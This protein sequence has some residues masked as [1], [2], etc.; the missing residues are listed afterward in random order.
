MRRALTSPMLTENPT[1]SWPP[2][3]VV[4]FMVS[5]QLFSVTWRIIWW[6]GNSWLHSSDPLIPLHFP[7]LNVQLMFMWWDI[8]L[9]SPFCWQPS[10][11]QRTSK[12]TSLKDWTVVLKEMSPSLKL[13]LQIKLVRI[14]SPIKTHRH[15][16]HG[17]TR[18]FW[19]IQWPKL[20]TVQIQWP[21]LHC[22]ICTLAETIS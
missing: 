9:W 4:N 3:W 13:D 6:M 7:V 21:N 5:T 12:G 11:G 8:I 19:P 10:F 14:D 16:G 2:G 15:A 18:R 20:Q 1:K 17:G 22:I